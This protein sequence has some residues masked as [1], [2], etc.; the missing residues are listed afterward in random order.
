[1]FALREVDEGG[2]T[3]VRVM[4]RA[5]GASFAVVPEFGANLSELVLAGYG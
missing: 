2:V 3:K 1:M 5:S 4:E